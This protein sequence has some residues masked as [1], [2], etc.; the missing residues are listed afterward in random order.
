MED[1]S[2]NAQLEFSNALDRATTIIDT[3]VFDS[4]L[5]KL[6]KN[7]YSSDTPELIKNLNRKF[8][9]FSSTTPE[10]ADISVYFF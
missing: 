3:L 7:P 5:E 10:L 9:F 6:L 8:R 2:Q 1:V 4:D